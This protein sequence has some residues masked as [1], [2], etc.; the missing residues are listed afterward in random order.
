MEDDAWY[1]WNLQNYIVR[2]EEREKH[3]EKPI[4]NLASL[5]PRLFDAH[6]N[7]KTSSPP[8]SLK[9]WNLLS[10]IHPEPC[11]GFD[12]ESANSTLVKSKSLDP[13]HGR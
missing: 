7:T 11:G 12:A 3:A 5:E 13:W 9:V 6:S 1:S 10:S 4:L 8:L 2:G